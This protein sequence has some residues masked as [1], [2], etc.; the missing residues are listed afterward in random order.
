MR[1]AVAD[2]LSRVPG[3]TTHLLPPIPPGF[4]ERDPDLAN[5]D[6]MAYDED[7]EDE[8]SATLPFSRK[9]SEVIPKQKRLLG[10]ILGGGYKMGKRG[11]TADVE[12]TRVDSLRNMY[13][14][15]NTEIEKNND[16]QDEEVDKDSQGHASKRQ[17]GKVLG[18][19][20]FRKRENPEVETSRDGDFIKRQF[21]R[22]LGGYKLGK[23]ERSDGQNPPIG[24]F[25]KRR[26]GRV[27]GTGF[28]LGKRGEGDAD[29]G[30]NKRRFG[31][32]LGG[33]GYKLGKRGYADT[34]RH[35]YT[36]A[37]K[38]QFGTILGGGGYK[39]GKRVTTNTESKRQFGK[40]LGNG[41]KLGKRYHLNVQS[42]T[43]KRQFGKVLGNG[44][45]LGKRYHLNVQSRT[46]KRQFGK[47]LGTSYKLGKRH[48][49]NVQ[50]RT[51]KRQF[52][53]VLGG[54]KLGKRE[55][56]DVDNLANKRQYGRILGNGYKLGKRFAPREEDSNTPW[57][58][59][60]QDSLTPTDTDGFAPDLSV[61]TSTITQQSFFVPMSP[62]FDPP[63]HPPAPD[64]GFNSVTSFPGRQLTFH[65]DPGLRVID[66]VYV[67]S[68]SDTELPE[69]SK[70]LASLSIHDLLEE[71][72]MLLN[73]FFTDSQV[74]RPS[75][76]T[77]Q[78][79][80]AS[81]NIS[82]TSED[83]LQADRNRHRGNT[84]TPA[85][86]GHSLFQQVEETVERQAEDTWPRGQE[87]GQ[88]DSEARYLPHTSSPAVEGDQDE[89]GIG[90]LYRKRS[91]PDMSENND[92][93]SKESQIPA[94]GRHFSKRWLFGFHFPRGYK[95][96]KRTQT[97]PLSSYPGGHERNPSEP[98][99][100]I[101]ALKQYV[102]RLRAAVNYSRRQHIWKDP[103]GY[104]V[105]RDA[106]DRDTAP[107][108][109][110]RGDELP[111]SPDSP[112]SQ[113]LPQDFPPSSRE[114]LTSSSTAG[115]QGNA[116]VVAP[117]S[118]DGMIKPEHLDT[119]VMYSDEANLY[120]RS[121]RRFAGHQSQPFEDSRYESVG[122]Q[123]TP[124][125]HWTWPY[126]ARYGPPF[127]ML[128]FK[129]RNQANSSADHDGE[130]SENIS[131]LF[132]SDQRAKNAHRPVGQQEQ[133]ASPHQSLYHK[134][135][136]Q[137]SEHS[138]QSAGHPIQQQALTPLPSEDK[139]F[140]WRILG[141]HRRRKER[142]ETNSQPRTRPRP[143]G[144]AG[145]VLPGTNFHKLTHPAQNVDLEQSGSSP[146][147][148]KRFWRVAGGYKLGKREE[149]T[150]R[151]ADKVTWPFGGESTPE[152]IPVT[153]SEERLQPASSFSLNGGYAPDGTISEFLLPGQSERTKRPFWHFLGGLTDWTHKV[154]QPSHVQKY[155]LSLYKRDVSGNNR[156]GGTDAAPHTLNSHS[157][158][159]D[160]LSSEL[161]SDNTAVQPAVES[162]DG[163]VDEATRCRG[164]APGGLKRLSKRHTQRELV[165]RSDLQ[166]RQPRLQTNPKTFAN[167]AVSLRELSEPIMEGYIAAE[168]PQ[169]S[170]P[171]QAET[172]EDSE[173]TNPD[174]RQWGRVRVPGYKAVQQ[175]LPLSLPDLL[176]LE[177]SDIDDQGSWNPD[178]NTRVA[179]ENPSTG[180]QPG[181]SLVVGDKRG[182][183][184]HT[185]P[186]VYWR[187][188][189]G[190]PFGK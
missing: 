86:P 157:Q 62:F 59:S 184:W 149:M 68:D 23:R 104:R 114:D 160:R 6:S 116:K 79:P 3:L 165:P 129:K 123:V 50:S 40:V 171:G 8:S 156:V 119:A 73:D 100:T 85:Q 36:M 82:L 45:K 110:D 167:M 91:E 74:S 125:Q 113:H 159:S 161:A 175:H 176:E 64:S 90:H 65:Q 168:H 32:I 72:Q 173:A 150:G 42:G 136:S 185:K 56:L 88:V 181:P 15:L 80:L 183:A 117:N 1:T 53:N 155:T 147:I 49:L 44:F 121:Q 177:S 89:N 174:A 61:A 115:Q 135:E 154:V 58:P 46:N 60:L 164:K 30:A 51:N 84:D 96:G 133:D 144:G 139:R 55:S 75:D 22:V 17:F 20:R 169:V 102:A 186:G 112:D 151:G 25:T 92:D 83:S 187:L 127:W 33:G 71:E 43:N 5:D 26:F 99:K 145:W 128:F 35:D 98:F 28:K 170:V 4:P 2:F 141:S 66:P 48:H 87:P 69:Q 143:A 158:P 190:Y 122:P 11:P 52:G 14:V 153:D 70:D 188:L 18:G 31:T 108:L 105:K 19:Y 166:E 57:Y 41:F 39:I 76:Q 16:L 162:L 94:E 38:R 163:T 27:L 134:Q 12:T 7:E 126:G 54:Y 111:A 93:V 130:Q 172:Y 67:D 179:D 107:L 178:L 140:Y 137:P 189:G 152:F 34:S 101:E 77:S 120:S 132:Q 21:G 106:D 10:N 81:D 124:V 180:G 29:G 13:D 95:L 97:S 131:V 9:E 182:S 146:E 47:V 142:P 37:L 63:T 109:A 78:F 103:R 148:G 138:K 24:S 118:R